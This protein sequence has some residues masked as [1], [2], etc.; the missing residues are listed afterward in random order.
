VPN[1]GCHRALGDVGRHHCIA[2]PGP[3]HR[4]GVGSTRVPRAV[5]P[6]IDTTPTG[7]P[8]R[9]V[10]RRDQTGRVAGGSC[11]DDPGQLPGPTTRTGGGHPVT[12]RRTRAT[13]PD[14]G[15]VSSR[16]DRGRAAGRSDSTRTPCQKATRSVIFCAAALGSGAVP[17]GIRVAFPIN[18]HVVVEGHALP[19]APRAVA[20]GYE[21]LGA[22]GLHREVVVPLHDHRVVAFSEHQT[23]PDRSDHPFLPHPSVRTGTRD[24]SGCFPRRST[25]VRARSAAK[26]APCAPTPTKRES[27]S[28]HSS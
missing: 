7:Q 15:V 8:G 3:E 25:G 10:S 14:L 18:D 6:E 1:P 27:M 16:G 26:L 19:E 24:P 23:I 17:G 28:E 21:V 22:E 12:S 13:N 5:L 2:P 9:H 11:R 20:T 4:Q